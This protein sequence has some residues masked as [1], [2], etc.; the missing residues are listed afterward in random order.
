MARL[1]PV[2]RRVSAPTTNAPPAAT[3]TA[4]AMATTTFQPWLAVRIAWS[5]AR[6][7]YLPGLRSFTESTGT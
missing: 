5:C 2:S 7:V 6:S 4:P 3:T 1:K